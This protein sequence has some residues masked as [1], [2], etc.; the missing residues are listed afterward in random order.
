MEWTQSETLALA[1]I[2]CKFCYGMGARVTRGGRLKPCSCV[3]RSIFR[4]CYARFR[5][6]VEKEKHLSVTTLDAAHRGGRRT[7]WGRKNE[8]YI[9]DFL[10]V[11]RKA[12]NEKDWRLFSAR[13][14]LCADW[15]LCARQLQIDRGVFFHQVYRVEQKL[16]WVY[17]NLAPYA[18]FPTDEYFHGASVGPHLKKEEKPRSARPDSLHLLLNV[19]VR[20]AA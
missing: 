8:E 6:S 18:L 7:T 12:L 16:G 17:R 5:S 2:S 3:L 9:A 14:L 1:R 10:S 13:Y 20:R 15:R 19:P 4:A 11:S